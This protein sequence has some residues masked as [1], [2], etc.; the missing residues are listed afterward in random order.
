MWSDQCLEVD[1]CSSVDGLEGQHYHLESN[2]GHNRKPVEF[3]VEVGHMEEFWKI[4][5]E[6][7][8]SVLYTLQQFSH[9]CWES[10][11]EEEAVGQ[12]GDDR[13][14]EQEL[15]CVF[16]EERPDPEEVVEGKSAVLGHSSG[17]VMLRLL[18]IDEG[19]TSSTVTDRSMLAVFSQ[20]EGVQF[21]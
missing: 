7:H 21:F 5:N 19:D 8:C 16:C 2:A 10:S 18:F 12:V 3:T 15:R 11:Q 20:D 13:S 4:V 6:A 14:L 17:V 9:R 1:G